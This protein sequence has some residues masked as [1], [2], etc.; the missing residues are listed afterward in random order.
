MILNKLRMETGAGM[1]RGFSLLALF[2][3]TV[4][5]KSRTYLPPITGDIKQ[6]ED[7]ISK[8]D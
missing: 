7:G 2:D 8:R 5:I 1:Q 3:L 4:Q 6:T